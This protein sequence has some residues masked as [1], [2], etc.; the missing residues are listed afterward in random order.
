MENIQD[1]PVKQARRKL[2]HPEGGGGGVGGR[3][4]GEKEKKKKS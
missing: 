2:C 1:K 3:V 4:G